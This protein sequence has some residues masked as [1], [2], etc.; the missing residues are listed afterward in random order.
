MTAGA[1]LPVTPSRGFNDNRAETEA[2]GASE[3]GGGGGGGGGV[4]TSSPGKR[5]GVDKWPLQRLA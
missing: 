4:K 1:G 5:R 3:G 2:K